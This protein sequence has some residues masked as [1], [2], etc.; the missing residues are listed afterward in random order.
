[1]KRI[2]Q[3]AVCAF[4]LLTG[5]NTFALAGPTEPA[6]GSLLRQDLL[7]A[8]RSLAEFEFGLPVEFVV[9]E[10]QA[11]GDLAFA[12]LLPQRPEGRV[13]DLE[14]TPMVVQRG[15]SPAAFDGAR[16]EVFLE[17]VEGSWRVTAS[18]TGATD[19]WWF[20]YRCDIYS[21]FLPGMGC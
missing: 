17:R 3:T 12:R 21:A 5:G 16:M 2:V 15:A 7:N 4:V 1:M 9:I 19:V 11:E 20:G 18:A 8:V 10:L 14:T 6:R 13:I